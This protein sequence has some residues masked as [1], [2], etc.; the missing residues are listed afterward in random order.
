M[1]RG[2]LELGRD[3]RNEGVL[4]TVFTG[5]LVAETK[6]AGHRAVIPTITGTAWVTGYARYVLDPDDPFP[7]GFTLADI[8]GAGPRELP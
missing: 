8:W 5:R 2:D 1:P 6:V 7:A 4:G 3:F